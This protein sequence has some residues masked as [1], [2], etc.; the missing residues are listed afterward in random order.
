MTGKAKEK[1]ATKQPSNRATKQ[2]EPPKS[3]ERNLYSVGCHQ[4]H[5]NTAVTFYN[6]ATLAK[7]KGDVTEMTRKRFSL[8]DGRLS[9]DDDRD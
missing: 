5:A 4:S 6:S 2:T 1:Q 9:C 7:A 3:E 8:V